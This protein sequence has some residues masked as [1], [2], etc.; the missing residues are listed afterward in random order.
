MIGWQ[1]SDFN[2]LKDNF[3]R[4]THQDIC[5]CDSWLVEITTAYDFWKT[6]SKL[7]QCF[8]FLMSIS[9]SIISLNRRQ[10]F[11][12]LRYKNS[13]RIHILHYQNFSFGNR[14]RKRVWWNQRVEKQSRSG[15]TLCDKSWA[16]GYLTI[17]IF[18]FNTIPIILCIHSYIYVADLIGIALNLWWIGIQEYQIFLFV[19]QSFSSG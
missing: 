17:F 10:L 8:I 1:K 3:L 19:S 15:A 4:N 5:Q 12:L 14:K 18:T 13:Y 6:R 16:R 11:H 7:R 2:T 9:L